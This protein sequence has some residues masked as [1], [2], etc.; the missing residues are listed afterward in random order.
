M[1]AFENLKAGDKVAVYGRGTLERRTVD[2]VTA[3]MFTVADGGRKFSR[4]SGREHGS[5]SWS[6]SWAEPW[7]DKHAEELEARKA[8][9]AARTRR[10]RLC[11]FNWRSLDDEQVAAAI[12]ALEAAGVLPVA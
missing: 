9:E 1:A 4:K 11:S 8:D 6:F 2:R 3:T 10:G 12:A 5:T 7:T